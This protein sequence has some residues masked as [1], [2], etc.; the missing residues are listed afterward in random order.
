MFLI[1]RK[2]DESIKIGDEITATILEAG[3]SVRPGVSVHRD[4]VYRRVVV[5]QQSKRLSHRQRR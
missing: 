2:A 1:T 3:N 4:E 5:T